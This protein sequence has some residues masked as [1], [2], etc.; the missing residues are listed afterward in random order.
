MLLIATLVVGGRPLGLE[1]TRPAVTRYRVT[2][3]A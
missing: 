1:R 2:I 3:Q